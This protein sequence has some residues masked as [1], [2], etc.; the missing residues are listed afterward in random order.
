MKDFNSLFFIGVHIFYGVIFIINL[1]YLYYEISLI[2]N[3]DMYE[4]RY[5][6]YKS[7]KEVEDYL[8][9]KLEK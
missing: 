9:R 3:L 4:S 6:S 7:F 1:D 8:L 5:I 2:V